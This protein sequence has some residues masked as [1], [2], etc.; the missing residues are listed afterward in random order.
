MYAAFAPMRYQCCL[1]PG[2]DP[3]LSWRQ[4]DHFTC[5]LLFVTC[6]LHHQCP[7]ST[8]FGGHSRKF[9]MPPVDLQLLGHNCVPFAFNVDGKVCLFFNKKHL[10]VLKFKLTDFFLRETFLLAQSSR[11]EKEM[12]HQVTILLCSEQWG[13]HLMGPRPF[14]LWPKTCFSSYSHNRG[15]Q[16]DGHVQKERPPRH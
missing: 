4:V 16:C 7:L 12:L 10:K 5:H 2:R 1:L 14:I 9:T 6:H 11:K 15:Q 3:T 13:C 8:F